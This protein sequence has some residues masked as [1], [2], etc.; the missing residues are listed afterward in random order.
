MSKLQMVTGFLNY[1]LIQLFFIR[2]FWKEIEETGEV[3]EYGIMG[4][5]RP[6]S[7]WGNE[8]KWLSKKFE[9]VVWRK[10]E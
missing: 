6:F 10:G 5:I 9:F 3:I 4:F 8:Y 7:G 1:F 2:I